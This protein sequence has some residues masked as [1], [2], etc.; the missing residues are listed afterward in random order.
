MADRTHLRAAANNDI[1]DDDPFAELTRIMGFDP[2]QPVRPQTPNQP[3]AAPAGQPAD[4]G[5]FDIDLEKEL[6]GE[7][8]A[9]DND[10]SAE[11]REPAFEAADPMNAELAASLEQDLLLDDDATDETAHGVSADDIDLAAELSTPAV[12]AA[13]D[14]DFEDAIASSLE[15][16]SPFEDDLD[17]KLADNKLAD[18]ELAA[19]L[20]QDFLL[21]D[22]V[23]DEPGAVAAETLAAAVQPD[24]DDEFGNAIASS[25][26]DE[27]MLDEHVPPEQQATAAGVSAPAAEPDFDDEFD[28][29]VSSSLE[30]EL[31]LDEHV[32]M[33]QAAVE[34][35]AAPVQAVSNEADEDL[36]GHFDEAMAD[37]DMDFDVRADESA[38]ID[39][40]EIDEPEVAADEL[41]AATSKD[42][43]DDDFDLNFDDALVDDVEEP[44]AQVASVAPQPTAPAVAAVQPAAAVAD[45]RSLEDEL[46]ALL[47][48]M[49]TRSVPLAAPIAA[50]AAAIAPREPVMAQQPVAAAEKAAGK[51]ADPVSEL[52]WDLDE[53]AAV[54]PAHPDEVQ[55]ADADLD[56]FLLDELKD[57]DFGAEDAAGSQDVDFDNDDLNAAFAR[58]I[59]LDHDAAG[60]GIAAD[61]EK[62]ELHDSLGWRTPRSTPPEPARSWSR[63]TPVANTQPAFASQPV[64]SVKPAPT[65]PP[66]MAAAP[67]RQE[68][69][70]AVADAA[71]A[72][73][74]PAEQPSAYDEMPDVETVDVPERVVALADDLDIPE[75][76]FEEDEPAAPAYDDLDSDFANLLTEMNA[77]DVAPTPVR[78]VAYDDE[79]Y[80]AG[81]NSGH[82]RDRVETRTYAARP[83]ETPA[84]AAYADAAGGFDLGELPGG[85]KPA[86]QA[87][88]FALDELDYD[89]ELDEAMSVPGL[90]EQDR[91]PRSRGLFIAMVVGAVA[92]AGGLGAFALSFGGRGSG[93]APVIVK[94]DNAPIKVKP[95]NPGGTVVPNQ[96]NKV[97]DAVVKGTKPA[98]PVQEKLVT[99]TEEPVDVT[100]KEPQSAVVDLGDTNAVEGAQAADDTQPVGGTQAAG[101]DVAAAPAPKSEDRI[102]QVLQEAEKSGNP[103]VVAVAPRKV[104]T[105]IVKSDG[106]LVAREDPA[107][108]APQVAAVEPA[109]PEPQRVAPSAQADNS[110]QTGTVPL[111]SG[112]ATEDQASSNQAEPTQPE[113]A[114]PAAAA[115]AESADTQSG[116]TQ[117]ANTPETVPLAPQ[118]PSDQPVDVVG[119]VKPDQVASIPTTASTGGGSWS[120][121]IASQPTVESAQSSYADLQ[122]RYGSVLAGRTAN[123][124]K[125]EIA[126]KGTFYRVRVPAQSRNDA[127]SLC[128]SYKAA[129]GNCFVSR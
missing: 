3:K 6:M 105:M 75:I 8:G 34:V 95:E 100:A 26:E 125:A 52:D 104:R 15:D 33:G 37:V 112:Q 121:Q 31:M 10:R 49:S 70:T 21:D 83:A 86:S 72:A 85:G 84:S 126:G 29:A 88:D 43:F 99:N 128:T 58:D 19:S 1:A 97:Y 60:D 82:Q 67:S 42:A 61:A 110:A 129:G 103:D 64:A 24:F 101:N 94:A 116:D 123:I 81:F 107:P 91:Q 38:E 16:V 22:D 13:F 23:T 41:S 57:Q 109:D 12:E 77:V 68:E 14:H 93:D 73:P 50:N 36:A 113:T 65:P 39:Q 28:N 124:V 127:I 46:N 20:E 115:K 32:P 11:V 40:P 114:K 102:A 4:E 56:T 48:A 96:D 18:D 66:A 17:D 108:A 44:V 53:H 51:P 2:R 119:E 98:E 9:D 122:R 74:A 118:R 62:E 78:S 120:M 47:G 111:A 71:Y 59:G 7:F 76:N 87:D 55:A 79:S 92:I 35:S 30:D 25:L 5:D 117:S 80:N 106:S 90:A 69:P 89:P 27:L 45:E 54:E 63:V